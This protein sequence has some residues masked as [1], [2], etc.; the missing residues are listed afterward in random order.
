ML[1]AIGIL[2][3]NVKYLNYPIMVNLRT[4]Y[5][6]DFSR[7]FYGKIAQ[8]SSIFGAKNTEKTEFVNSSHRGV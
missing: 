6:L 7:I 5:Q 3:A 2:H 4:V 8:T 1:R